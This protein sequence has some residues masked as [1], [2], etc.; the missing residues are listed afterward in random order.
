MSANIAAARVRRFLVVAAT[1][2]AAV[3]L[4]LAAAASAG[5]SGP[6]D[7]TVT[8]DGRTYGPA[9]DT[10][11]NPIVIPAESGL[12]AEWEGHTDVVITKHSG[13]VGVVVGP[14]AIPIAK[15]AGDNAEEAVEA[16]DSYP[17]DSARDLLPV[18]LVGLYQVEG[19]HDGEGGSCSGSAM[20]R[21][22]GNPLATPV[23][24]GA[25]VG[26]LVT[27]AALGA[28]AMGRKP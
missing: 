20:V 3:A 25:A 2:T 28:A 6:C 12:V 13:S 18:D 9:N 19:K 23:G 16:S 21:I 8:I 10:P 26:T 7:G 24:A 27:G 22:E 5:V 1:V 15:W 17:I 4:P 11:G 14:A